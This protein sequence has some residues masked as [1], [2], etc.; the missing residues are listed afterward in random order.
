[1][2]Q[3]ILL[4]DLAGDLVVDIWAALLAAYPPVNAG[5]ITAAA[6]PTLSTDDESKDTTLTGWTVNIPADTILRFNID[7]VATITRAVLALP[8]RLQ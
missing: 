8:Y 5:S 2:N 7:S 4:S 6:P 3:H 1:M